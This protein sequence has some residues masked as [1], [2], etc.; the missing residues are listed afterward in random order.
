MV[1]TANRPDTKVLPSAPQRRVFFAVGLLVAAFLIFFPTKQLIA[2]KVRMNKLQTRLD[3]LQDQNRQLKQQVDD[4]NDPEQLELLARDRLGL[5]KPGEKSYL[6][7]P[8]PPPARAETVQPKAD[9]AWYVRWW[10]S[11]WNFVRGS[12]G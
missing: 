8:T 5:V 11:A 2:Q 7:V 9:E 4:L 12:G 3:A 1:R 6:F 10:H